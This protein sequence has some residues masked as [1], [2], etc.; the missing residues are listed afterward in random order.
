MV[1]L[2]EVAVQDVAAH[3]FLGGGVAGR[4]GGETGA[5]GLGGAVGEVLAADGVGLGADGFLV[6]I[7]VVDRVAVV[8]AS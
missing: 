5:V 1:G 3:D 7:A 8:V 2:D 6:D 4:A